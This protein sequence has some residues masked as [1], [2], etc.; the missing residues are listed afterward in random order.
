MN[1]Y[2]PQI[3]MNLQGEWPRGCEIDSLTSIA[4]KKCDGVDGVED[5]II[6][7]P[8]ACD[9]FDP[10]DEVGSPA[11]EC[12][13]PSSG[14]SET[15]AYV[16]NAT[17]AGIWDEQGQPIFFAPHPGTDLT[18]IKTGAGIAAT[19]CQDE[20]QECAGAPLP[21]GPWWISFF[22]MKDPDFDYENLTL[23]QFYDILRDS[24][25]EYAP[26]VGSDNPDLSA[27]RQRGGKMITYHGLV[28]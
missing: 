9:A 2:W 16:A 19:T 28:S 6:S 11:D 15:T 12:A 17:W 13:D 20:G 7:D 1:W 4:I 23:E 24:R 21:L 25:D 22:A 5:G 3:Q 18:G 8:Y 14:I 27:F 10:F 26:Y